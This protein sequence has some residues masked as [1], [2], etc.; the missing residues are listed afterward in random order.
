[1]NVFVPLPLFFPSQNAENQDINRNRN[2]RLL[3][4][5][6]RNKFNVLDLPNPKFLKNF[7]LTKETFLHI[8]H[9]LELPSG[10]RST[11]ISPILQLAITLN[12][13]GGGAY[14]RQ[15]GADWSA[16]IA[17]ST[18]CEVISSTLKKMERTLCP[19]KIKFTP[20]NSEATKRYF[21][22]K[23]D[24]PGVIGCIDG[25]HIMILRPSDNE[26]IYFNRKGRH[27]LNAMIICDESRKI[28]SINA[29]Y[30]GSAHDSFVWRQSAQREKL[31]DH[32]CAGRTSSWLLG[33]SGYPLEPFLIT[34]YRNAAE[35]SPEARFNYVHS[36]AR[37]IVERCIGVMKTRWRSIL[38][39]RKLR[40]SP[41]KSAQIVNVCAALHNIC[42]EHTVPLPE[43]VLTASPSEH[44]N[45]QQAENARNEGARTRNRIRD[46]LWAKRPRL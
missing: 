43:A 20:S 3:R 21:Y 7:R 5:N 1:M 24:I 39:E 11:H 40:Y 12:F 44:S 9:L 26:H 33:D 22:E 34:P 28:L 35:N 27:S 38:E 29:K 36:Q 8:L 23:Y 17:Q 14:Q 10:I 45:N 13:L 31:N 30:G 32:F 16:P 6:L 42:C 15:V 19:L 4:I 2:V 25:S 46:D 41:R 18:V 37:S